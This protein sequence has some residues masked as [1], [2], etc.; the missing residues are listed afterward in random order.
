[1]KVKKLLATLILSVASLVIPLSS[2]LAASGWQW[3]DYVYITTWSP[4][5]KKYKSDVFKS[6]GGYIKACF[7][8][9]ST[10]AKDFTLYS[11][12]PGS[13]NDKKVGSTIYL[14]NKQCAEW[15]VKPYVDGSNKKAELY[16]ISTSGLS[17]ANIWD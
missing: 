7:D 1:M 12:N 4:T 3:I 11:Y 14:K 17:G 16:F 10:S 15:Y 5:F 2:V 13:G 6:G 8:V 9:A